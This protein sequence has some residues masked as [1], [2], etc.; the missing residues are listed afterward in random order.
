MT[1]S[2]HKVLLLFDIDG[3][4][5]RINNQK[6]HHILARALKACGIDSEPLYRQRF[7]GRTDRDIFLSVPGATDERFDCIR[8]HYEQLIESELTPENIEIIPGVRSTLE[9]LSQHGYALG[10]ITGNCRKAAFTKLEKANLDHYFTIGGFGDDHRDRNH[11]PEI[12]RVNAAEQFGI[13]FSPKATLVIGD[14]PNDIRCARFDTCHS[15]AVATGSYSA[16]E[17]SAHSPGLLLKTLEN[18]RT[19]L[20]EYLRT[21]T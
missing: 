10:L 3:T 18:P 15:I 5:L 13:P 9:F 6:N 1:D 8:N 14:T 11:L 21:F 4:L 16:S 7:A 2:P 17:L 12:A 20:N 19:W